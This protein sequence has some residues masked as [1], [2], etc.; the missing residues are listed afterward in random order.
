VFL[1]LLTNSL[2]FTKIEWKITLKATK[3]KN[4]VKFEII[5][6]W[7]WIPVDKLDI[8]FTKF[9]QVESSMQRQNDTWLGLWLAICKNFINQFGSDIKVE[10]KVWKWSN[11]NFEL[12]LK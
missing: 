4:K 8:L 1:N 11:F 10:S 12:E 3:I 6:N 7:I 2:K 9:S 5:D